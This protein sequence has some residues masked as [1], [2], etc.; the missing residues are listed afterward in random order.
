MEYDKNA[1]PPLEPKKTISPQQPM[2]QVP[3]EPILPL[4]LAEESL[5]TI[6]E[7]PSTENMD[8]MGMQMI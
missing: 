1:F 8:A 5:S 7:A 4:P 2:E 6:P 3:E